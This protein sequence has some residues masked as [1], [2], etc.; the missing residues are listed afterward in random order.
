MA[1]WMCCTTILFEEQKAVGSTQKAEWKIKDI[2]T[3]YC[4]VPTD[5]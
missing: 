5:V 1:A 2:I 3:A 4:L